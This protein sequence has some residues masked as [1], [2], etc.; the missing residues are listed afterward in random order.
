MFVNSR[1]LSFFHSF[2]SL[3]PSLKRSSLSFQVEY[4]AF[5]GPLEATGQDAALITVMVVDATGQVQPLANHYIQFSVQGNS[6]FIN[7]V[8]NGDPSSHEPDKAS[9]RS[10]WHGLARVILQT[11]RTPGTV[12]LT[13]T[14]PGLTSASIQLVVV[15]P[16]NPIPII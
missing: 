6:A 3:P 7:G 8:G 13:A 15:A 9:G 12:T 11:T 10:V 14:S 5:R 2:S 16:Q 4:P 1:Y